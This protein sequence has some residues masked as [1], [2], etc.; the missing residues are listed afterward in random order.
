MYILIYQL[1]IKESELQHPAQN[2][3]FIFAQYKV[4]KL[5]ISGWN[6]LQS[7]KNQQLMNLIN[8]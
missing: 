5:Y 2:H 7:I 1:Y 3:K 8:K 6:S 4:V